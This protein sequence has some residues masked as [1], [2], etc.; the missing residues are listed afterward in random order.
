[1]LVPAVKAVI[2]CIISGIITMKLFVRAAIL[3]CATIQALHCFADDS[4]VVGSLEAIR[5]NIARLDAEPKKSPIV[6]ARLKELRRNLRELATGIDDGQVGEASN[7]DWQ[8]EIR[9]LL[10]PLLNEVRRATQQPREIERLRR[11]VEELGAEGGRL[12]GAQ[13]RVGELLSASP[14]AALAQEL[15]QLKDELAGQ[16]QSIVTQL[17]I[18]NHKLNTKLADRK[19]LSEALNDIFQVF[20]KIRGINLLIALGA[21]FIF[22]FVARR[23]QIVIAR[24]IRRNREPTFLSRIASIV[25]TAGAGVGAVLVFMLALY[26]VG[27]WVLL[28]LT[29]MLFLGIVWTSKQAVQ[30]LW[31]H[32]SLL[33]NMGS[34]REGE[35]VFYRGLPWKVSSVNFLSRLDNPAL[36][37]AGLTLPMRDLR[38]LRSREIN[39]TEPWFPSRTGDWVRLGGTHPAQ[40]LFQGVEYVVLKGTNGGEV[41]IPSA[42]YYGAKIENLSRGFSMQVPVVVNHGARSELLGR[43]RGAMLVEITNSLRRQLGGL[44]NLAIELN[45]VSEVGLEVLVVADFLGEAAPHF[46]RARRIIVT[47]AFEVMNRTSTNL[48]ERHLRV[49]EIEA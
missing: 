26:F 28:L 43:L 29:L 6:E 34:V 42:E 4:G 38:D 39:P 23:V 22:W 2:T 19:T 3:F 24:L 15:T 13:R 11:T 1:L 40:V 25:V 41:S 9:D 48:P 16:H 32:A 33:M 5:S 18:V 14:S 10:N 12:E 8:Q 49:T 27:D 20:F 21:A 36:D 17:E 47:A 7:A 37:G 45:G 35:R 44:R 31:S 46:E 30:H